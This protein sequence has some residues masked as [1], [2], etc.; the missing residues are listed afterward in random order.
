MTFHVILT[1]ASCLFAGFMAVYAVAIKRQMSRSEQTCIDLVD[2][3]TKEVKGIS[4]GSM[5]I[6]RKTLALEQRIHDLEE[7]LKALRDHDS[8][9]VSYAEAAR[10]VEMG[11]GIDELMNACRISRPE[12][13]LVAAM[14]HH[15]NEKVPTLVHTA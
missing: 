4:H 7:E 11:A 10:L 2:E 12:A 6:G 14:S 15:A 1:L 3:L 8:I 5:G 13:E 9:E